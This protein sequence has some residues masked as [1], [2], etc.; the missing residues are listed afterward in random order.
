MFLEK[1]APGLPPGQHGSS[2]DAAAV[3]SG[4]LHGAGVVLTH[5]LGDLDAESAATMKSAPARLSAGNASP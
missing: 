1:D 3:G 2:V 5:C 4:R